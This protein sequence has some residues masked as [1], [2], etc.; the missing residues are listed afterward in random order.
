MS[1]NNDLI[2]RSALL[3]VI[4]EAVAD[5]ESNQNEI[6][7][8]EGWNDCLE[9]FCSIVKY[10]PAVDAVEVVRCKDCKFSIP[11]VQKNGSALEGT[12]HCLHGRGYQM[13]APDREYSFISPNNFCGSGRR[14]MD[15]EVQDGTKQH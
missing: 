14:K 7:Y 4:P 2:S 15:A 10:A 11:V 12:L 6:A 1:Q 8:A 9:S 5:E 3:E 13:N